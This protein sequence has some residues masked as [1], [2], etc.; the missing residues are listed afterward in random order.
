MK[1]NFGQAIE[2][3]KKGEKVC[4]EG[5]NGKGMYIF[6]NGGNPVNGYLQS[7]HPDSETDGETIHLS[8]QMLEFIVIKTA[9][10]SKFWG[11][12]YSDYVCWLPSQ[13][14]ILSDDWM[15]ID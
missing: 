9:G 7:A 3:I 4:R 5:W 1:L 12:G 13:T 10:D 14:D 15:I 2:A 11:E 8:G 6:L